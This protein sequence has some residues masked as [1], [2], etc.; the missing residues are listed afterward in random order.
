MAIGAYRA[1]CELGL[2]VPTDVAL[3]GCDGIEDTEYLERPISTIEQ[4]ISE[5][6]ALAWDFLQRRI[7]EP[8]HPPQRVVLQPKLVI[9]ASSQR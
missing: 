6:C 9:R 4:P 5:M 1:L 3:V 2:R 7:Q 8:N